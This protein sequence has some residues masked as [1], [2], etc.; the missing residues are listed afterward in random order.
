MIKMCYEQYKVLQFNGRLD[1]FAREL[2]LFLLA[3]S[4]VI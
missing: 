3:P 4:N 1:D 2:P